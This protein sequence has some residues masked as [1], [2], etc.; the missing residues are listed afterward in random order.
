MKLKAILMGTVFLSVSCA[1]DENGADDW[2]EPVAATEEKAVEAKPNRGQEIQYE[3]L[4]ADSVSNT[5]VA[6]PEYNEASS[7]DEARTDEESDNIVF[8]HSPND[9][10]KEAA[11][12][13]VAKEGA[14]TEDGIYY[15]EK[16]LETD[17]KSSQVAT[18][19]TSVI[20]LSP[21]AFRVIA[22]R[23]NVRQGPG[24]T[25][26]VVGVLTNGSIIQVQSFHNGWAKI[27]EGQYVSMNYLRNI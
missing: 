4:S 25:H 1:G 12:D 24:L 9:K 16:S 6:E 26:I 27:A 5:I 21:G 17:L 20:S 11:D 14:V 7:E 8:K 22:S 10:K 15:D 23:L 2:A 13:Y 18:P 3:K 19:T